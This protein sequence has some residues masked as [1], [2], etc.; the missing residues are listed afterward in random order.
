MVRSGHS[1]AAPSPVEPR[2]PKPAQKE[3]E[4][5]H[6]ILS[7]H[8]SA[9]RSTRKPTGEPRLPAREY[10]QTNRSERCSKDQPCDLSLNPGDLQEDWSD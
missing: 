7:N 3:A 9:R 2:E 4:A 1:S 5:E 8:R 10:V 6:A